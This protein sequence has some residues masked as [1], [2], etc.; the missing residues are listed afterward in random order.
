MT[1]LIVGL[2]GITQCPSVTL[3]LGEQFGGRFATGFDLC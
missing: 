1:Q 2:L 3:V